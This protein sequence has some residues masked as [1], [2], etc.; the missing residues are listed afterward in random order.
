MWQPLHHGQ[1]LAID[2]V[3]KKIDSIDTKENFIECKT[4]FASQKQIESWC[5]MYQ[6]PTS[7]WQFRT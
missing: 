4:V 5:R 7:S 1:L 6:G 3:F 2:G